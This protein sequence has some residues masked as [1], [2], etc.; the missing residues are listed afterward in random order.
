[1]LLFV[2]PMELL[3]I[4]N[5]ISNVLGPRNTLQEFVLETNL[6]KEPMEP[7]Q[8]VIPVEMSLF[9]FVELTPTHIKMPVKPDA[10]EFPLLIK[11]NVLEITL[12]INVDV[13][14]NLIQFAE[15]MEELIIMLVK[16]DVK[17]LI[18]YTIQ[19]VETSIQTTVV[20]YVETLLPNLF[21][22]KI[23]KPTEMNVLLLNV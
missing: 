17:I 4:I 19:L 2:D 9:L 3:M 11:E 10:K 18:F 5:V 8:T 23:G 21:V 20:I 1:M 14:K 7:F 16:L 13:H 22:E 12:S 6:M 15:E